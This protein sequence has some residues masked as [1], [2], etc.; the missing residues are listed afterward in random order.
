MSKFAHL[1][2][3]CRPTGYYFRRRIPALRSTDVGVEKKVSNSTQTGSVCLS[4][5]TQFQRDAKRLARKLTAASDAL[6]AART[7][8]HMP[9]LAETMIAILKAVREHEIS[10]HEAVRSGSAERSPAEVDA[11]LRREAAI[12]EALR[13]AIALGKRDMAAPLLH[14]AAQRLGILLDANDPDFPVLSH[15]A[16]RLLVEISAERARREAGDYGVDAVLEGLIGTPSRPAIPTFQSRRAVETDGLLATAFGQ[17]AEPTS[18]LPASTLLQRAFG[19]SEAS[20]TA[21][22]PVAPVA[23]AVAPGPVSVARHQAAPAQSG[24]PPSIIAWSTLLKL[25]TIWRTFFG[26]MPES[27]AESSAKCLIL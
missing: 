26:T 7:E 24:Q 11:A 5:R 3:E 6:F 2:L 13:D 9:I 18:L 16:T 12:Q 23:P 17:S 15:K 21:T 22:A 19:A 4:L 14:A 27:M 25:G 8:Q 10:A 1:H 20:R